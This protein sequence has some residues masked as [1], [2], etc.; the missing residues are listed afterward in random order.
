MSRGKCAGCDYV[1]PDGKARDHIMSCPGFAEAYRERG[2]SIGTVEQVYE[3]WVREGRPRA[4]AEAHAR[5]VAVTDA[6]RSAMAD[7]FRTKDILED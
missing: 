4:R 1:G 5:S 2:Q 7:R 6:R 3:E